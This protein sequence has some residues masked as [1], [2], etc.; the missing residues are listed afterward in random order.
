[1]KKPTI[2]NVRSRTLPSGKTTYFLDYVD[3]VTDE[4]K[5]LTVGSR[6]ADAQKKAKEIYDT[7]MA[8][9]VGEPETLRSETTIDDLVASFFRSR[10]GRNSQRTI[11]RYQ[12]FASHFQ[13]FMANHFS[14][15]KRASE[16]RRVYLEELLSHLAKVG[17]EPRTL[18]AELNFLK[19]LF[20]YGIEENFVLDSPAQRIKPFRE[21][22][23]AEAV[24][25]W[26]EDEVRA[27]LATVRPHW[28]SIF[29]FLYQTGLRKGELIHL[30]WDD[31]TLTGKQPALRVQAKDDWVT[32][33]ISRR[34]VPLS[35]RAIEILS[36]LKKSPKHNRV[37]SGSEGGFIHP[38]KIYNELKL[39][40]K[41]L[42]LEGDV[43][44]WRHT[45][46]SHLVMKGVGLE[47]VSKL[48]GH[49]SIEMTMKYAHLA[50]A[51]LQTAV[52][53]LPDLS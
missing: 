25:F 7:M 45:F 34:V 16:I 48:L 51:H 9:F 38:D 37:F 14:K 39:A 13:E 23:K 1:M 35:S 27:I 22:K 40:L 21:T 43:H 47:T 33:T 12:I 10:E 53:E 42:G 11:R 29:E 8:R 24:R 32:K 50:P 4:R 15:V 3:I 28:K 52:N 20:K 41:K 30:T 44:Q 46:A 6:K 2:P 5:R 19:M 18:N 17:Q 49:A 31:V 36:G 26:S